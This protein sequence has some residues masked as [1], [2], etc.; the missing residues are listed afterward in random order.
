MDSSLPLDFV[1]YRLCIDHQWVFADGTN[2]HAIMHA[3]DPKLA[4]YLYYTDIVTCPA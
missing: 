2:P 3:N 4:G 1:V